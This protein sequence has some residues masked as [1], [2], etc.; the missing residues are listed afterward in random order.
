M[1]TVAI[2]GQGYIGTYLQNCLRS[3]DVNVIALTRSSFDYTNFY[4]VQ[5]FL[6][7]TQVDYVINC[8]GFTGRPNIE[9]AEIKKDECWNANV[10]VPTTINRICRERGINYIFVST[11]CIY[12]GYDK[13]FSENDAPNFGLYSD[14]APFYSKTKH[15]YELTAGDF[16]MT[17]RIRLP[18]CTVNSNRSL[19]FKVL[20]YDN[21][22]NNRNSKTSLKDLGRFLNF[23]IHN[24]YNVCNTGILNFTN[25]EPLLITDIVNLL[26]NHNH[27]NPK[28]KIVDPTDNTKIVRSNCTLST[29]KLS[30]LFPG[31]KLQTE[32]ESIVE[33]LA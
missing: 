7:S 17:L 5:N 20:A 13:P 19:L 1:K 4:N 15:A 22:L 10:T 31:F 2:I 3:E 25:P 8:A 16:G 26:K 24:E 9:E 6:D 32:H 18:F 33:A 29:E 27:R 21:L 12:N 14:T 11:G 30:N 23:I 28:W